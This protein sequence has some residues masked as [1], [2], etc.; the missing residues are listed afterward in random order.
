LWSG[1]NTPIFYVM[2]LAT[3]WSFSAALHD[4]WHAQGGD[5]VIRRST[6]FP[7]ESWRRWFE[8]KKGEWSATGIMVRTFAIGITIECW[9]FIHWLIRPH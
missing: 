6:K 7:R 5:V 9:I 4:L 8:F 3:F 2:N 1:L